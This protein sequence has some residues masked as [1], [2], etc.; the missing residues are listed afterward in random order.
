MVEDRRLENIRKI[1]GQD[2]SSVEKFYRKTTALTDDARP[3]RE[4][5]RFL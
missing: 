1:E 2:H 5:W 3:N 4:K